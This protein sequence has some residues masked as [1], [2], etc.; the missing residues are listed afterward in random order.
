[1]LL[2]SVQRKYCAIGIYLIG[3]ENPSLMRAARDDADG[4]PGKVVLFD[5]ITMAREWIPQLSLG[6]PCVWSRNKETITFRLPP[7]VMQVGPANY[8]YDK[9]CIITDYDPYNLPSGMPA[10]LKSEVLGMAWKCH[11]MWSAAFF[12][13]GGNLVEQADGKLVNL[14]R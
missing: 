4:E 1:M 3:H 11:I 13:V 5:T 8:G 14:A 9:A 6:R 7:D 2:K 12:D 10:D